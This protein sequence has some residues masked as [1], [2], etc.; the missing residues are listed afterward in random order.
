MKKEKTAQKAAEEI[1]SKKEAKAIQDDSAWLGAF[2]LVVEEA[3]L[4]G[5]LLG[6]GSSILSSF[7]RKGYQAQHPQVWRWSP[8]QGL[9]KD[10]P[11]KLLDQLL[12]VLVVPVPPS[13]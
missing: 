1:A 13:Q 10:V 11:V 4:V 12:V 8:P 3:D 7:L 6:V 2:L 5:L 9:N